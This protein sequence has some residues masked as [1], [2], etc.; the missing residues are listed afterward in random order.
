MAPKRATQTPSSEDPVTSSNLYPFTEYD[1]SPLTKASYFLS[2]KRNLFTTVSGS[3]EMISKGHRVLSS[4]GGTKVSFFSLKHIQD[5]MAGKISAGTVDSP[6]DHRAK[7]I[8]ATPDMVIDLNPAAPA[9][10]G[11]TVT[12]AMI[13]PTR[14]SQLG[15]SAE[16]FQ[17]APEDCDGLLSE[18]ADYWLTNISSLK[19]RTKWE[20][21]ADTNGILLM[22]KF[23]ADCVS[24]TKVSILDLDI[25]LV[26][27]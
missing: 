15:P 17:V 13:L 12:V 27:G 7:Y 18:I 5:Y 4:R 11:G 24:G 23:K 6:V 21:A 25:A 10:S 19:V 22:L 8:S 16:R 9:T 3:R 26:V 1:G 2:G 20:K 14:A